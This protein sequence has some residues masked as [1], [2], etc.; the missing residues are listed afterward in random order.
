[1]KSLTAT[2]VFEDKDEEFVR[3]SVEILGAMCVDARVHKTADIPIKERIAP[4]TKTPANADFGAVDE[5]KKLHG[6]EELG[7]IL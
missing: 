5:G 1:M 6:Y 4:E 7:E 2:F 3:K